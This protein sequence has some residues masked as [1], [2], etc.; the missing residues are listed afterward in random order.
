[1]T[2][3]ACDVGRGSC[4]DERVGHDCDGAC[5]RGDAGGHDRLTVTD[6][7]HLA[8]DDVVGRCGCEI[9]ALQHDCAEKTDGRDSAHNNNIHHFNLG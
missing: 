4:V 7:D 9:D 6:C 3:C 8:S 5:G 1:M 2:G